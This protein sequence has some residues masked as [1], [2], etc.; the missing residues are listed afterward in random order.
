MAS[1]PCYLDEN[2]D[3]QRG[4]GVFQKSL[5]ALRRLN[6]LGYGQPGSP[7]VL[8][9][10]FN[11]LGP[12]LPPPQAQLEA[13][14]RQEL[15]TRYGVVFNR[16]FT[17]TNMPISRFLDDLLQ[18]GQYEAYLQRLV[19]AFNPAAAAGVMCR[20][21]LSVDWQGRLY[22]C[23]FNQMLDLGLAHRPATGPSTSGTT[24]TAGCAQVVRAI[25]TGRHCFAC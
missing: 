2:V 3:R 11:P 10:V 22:D 9:L 14:Y 24:G 15:Q 25:V 5:A 16:L 13:A 18:T 17:I 19:D 1:L 7:R 21:M 12:S 4:G 8:T 20:T 23:D 6:A